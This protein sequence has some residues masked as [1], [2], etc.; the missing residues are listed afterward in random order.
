M[1]KAVHNA[2]CLLLC[3]CDKCEPHASA[4]IFASALYVA[5]KLPLRT[6][7]TTSGC[8]FLTLL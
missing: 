2:E 7:I 5:Y 3:R 8:L 4:T 1:P 6:S